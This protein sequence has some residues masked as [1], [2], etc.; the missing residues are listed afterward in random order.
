[1]F[2]KNS[3]CDKYCIL[4]FSDQWAAAVL[5]GKLCCIFLSFVCRYYNWQ[6]AAP[7]LMSHV[8]FQ[9]P[10]KQV[11]MP[12]GPSVFLVKGLTVFLWVGEA[13]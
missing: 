9:R 1:M 11:Q 5:Y 8:L 7:M 12:E 10:L 2:V 3:Y 13:F 6:I 4:T